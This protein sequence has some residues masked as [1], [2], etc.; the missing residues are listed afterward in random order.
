MKRAEFLN[1]QIDFLKHNFRPRP[2]TNFWVRKALK[3]L[4]LRI[5]NLK[6][7]DIFAGTGCIGIAIL[8]NI[9]NSQIDFADIS[10]NATEQIKINLKLNKIEKSRCKIYRANLFEKMK[11]K[12]YDFIFANP[13]YVALDRILEVQKEVLK[14][15]PPVALFAGKDGLVIIEKFL[16]QV[17]NYLKPSGKIFLEFDPLQ[18]QKIE[19]I[20]K[21]EGFKVVFKKDQFKK[22]R[23]LS[24]V[25]I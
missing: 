2:E 15:E 9:K 19:R 5:K 12:K 22:Y 7:L 8:K 21:E 6:I 11:G 20:A 1:C 3:D 13:P 25:K 17:K 24:A 18:R 4:K 16:Q 23:W 10:E 14:K